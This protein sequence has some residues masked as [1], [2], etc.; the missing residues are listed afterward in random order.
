MGSIL[1]G[2]YG[3]TRILTLTMAI[4]LTTGSVFAQT[5]STTSTTGGAANST[6]SAGT[7]TSAQDASGGASKSGKH[8]SSHKSAHNTAHKT[9]HHDAAMH[10]EAQHGHQ[11]MGR[12]DVAYRND[13][14]QC[15]E[16]PT[17][18]RDACLDQ[19]VAHHRR[20]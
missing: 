11:A 2:E 6:N 1:R 13:L 15:V 8:K 10:H 19:A 18:N 14:R 12:G 9:A 3:M 5:N 20:S 17:N 7:T 16:G 4:A